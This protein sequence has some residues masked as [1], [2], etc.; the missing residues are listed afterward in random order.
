MKFESCYSFTEKNEIEKLMLSF[1]YFPDF[2]YSPSFT[3]TCDSNHSIIKQ[4]KLNLM[5]MII[6]DDD[7]RCMSSDFCFCTSLTNCICTYVYYVL[8]YVSFDGFI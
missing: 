5:V 7:E 1:S 8:C 6:T 4:I 3:L 2:S